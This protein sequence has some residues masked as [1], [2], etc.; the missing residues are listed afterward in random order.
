M[1]TFKILT[2]D[3]NLLDFDLVD[4]GGGVTVPVR[5]DTELQTRIG[6]T[7][8]SAAGSDTATSGLNGLFKRL[9]QRLT[10]LI[11]LLPTSLEN[12]RFR[13][14]ASRAYLEAQNTYAV[15]TTQNFI[16]QFNTLG[17]SRL[18]IQI[19]NT[20]ANTITN[21]NTV[22][23]YY[24]GSTITRILANNSSGYGSTQTALGANNPWI[25]I[26]NCS[27]NLATLEAGTN[28]FLE[29]NCEGLA[30]VRFSGVSPSGTNL[31]FSSILIS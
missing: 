21:L 14:S 12:G 20:G 27:S 26:I 7:N 22:I 1:P 15:P 13:T 4:L 2:A 24:P 29:F 3:N 6:A 17:Y 30:F 9:L 11:N 8:E 19:E 31:R 18:S 16:M 25:R 23:G 5:S 28:G 10:V